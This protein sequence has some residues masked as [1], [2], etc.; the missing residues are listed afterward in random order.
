MQE[1]PKITVAVISYN[2]SATIL[3][4]L[5]SVFLQ[6]YDNIELVI[7][8]DGSSDETENICRSWIEEKGER[9]KSIQL[10]FG[11]ENKGTTYN[12]NKAIGASTGEWVTIMAADDI[13]Y[14]NCLS[15]YM[16]FVEKNPEA[17]WIL[18]KFHTYLNT[19]DESNKVQTADSKFTQEWKN[20]FELSA[21]EQFQVLIR[22]NFI[23]SPNDLRKRS[24]Y[25]IS[26]MFDTKYGLLEDYSMNLMATKNGLK[27]YLLDEYL[28]GYRRG[29]SNVAASS[30]KFFNLRCDK[31]RMDL[32]KD[33]CFEYYKWNEVAYQKSLYRLHVI[34]ERLHMN[35]SKNLLFKILYHLSEKTLSLIFYCK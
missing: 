10:L 31:N 1:F 14:P 6:D 26:G 13:M 11:E 24:S 19:F 4:T 7:S 30:S 3:D 27:C 33:Y 5:N 2:S 15:S 12:C 21:Q 25:E 18:V 35:N 20:L 9:F 17:S 22:Y 23:C 16:R 28:Y 29:E 32:F 8:D 34:F